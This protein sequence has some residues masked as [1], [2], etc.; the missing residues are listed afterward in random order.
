MTSAAVAGMASSLNLLAGAWLIISPFVLD[1][2]KQPAPLW[3]AVIVGVIVAVSAA[4]RAYLPH[5]AV[6]L[7]WLNLVLG[8]WLIVSPFAL[9]YTMSSVAMG[10]ALILGVI[11]GLLGLWSAL[12]THPMGHRMV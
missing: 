5:R 10:N 12:A 7:S 4:A 8:M 9:G 2:G 11:V 6:G 3:N 1:F